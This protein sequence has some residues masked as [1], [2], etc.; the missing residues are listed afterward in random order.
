MI[1]N[2]RRCRDYHWYG[3]DGRRYLDMR[4]DEGGA[5]CGHRPSRLLSDIKQ[6]LSRG[7]VTSC[8]NRE[9]E[10]SVKL[11]GKLFTVSGLADAVPGY[12]MVLLPPG[13]SLRQLPFVLQLHNSDLVDSRDPRGQ[14]AGSMLMWRPGYDV[15]DTLSEG[16]K[17]V[18]DSIAAGK[19]P[20]V[21]PI[22]PVPRSLCPQPLFIPEEIP[23]TP[24]MHSDWARSPVFSEI[25]LKSLVTGIEL[26]FSPVYPSWS[27][28]RSDIE[29]FPESFKARAFP[30]WYSSGPYQYFSGS[31]ER[32][33]SWKIAALN[34][35]LLLPEDPSIAAIMPAVLSSKE[36]SLINAL[37]DSAGCLQ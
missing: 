4:L 33:N 3:A 31:A 32:Y 5:F 20:I 26:F 6:I 29:W 35:G 23:D 25:N 18:S 28:K 1:G 8:V 34:L 21:A 24:I 17:A 19:R 13:L 7:T 2:V 10:R 14:K 12:K 37:P 16:K 36:N 15:E 22:L 9:S 11:L 30:E 27:T